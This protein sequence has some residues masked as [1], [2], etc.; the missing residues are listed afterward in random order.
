MIRILAALLPKSQKTL[1]NSIPDCHHLSRKKCPVTGINSGAKDL[2]RFI[3]K[4]YTIDPSVFRRLPE[5]LH[6]L[7]WVPVFYVHIIHFFGHF[8]IFLRILCLFVAINQ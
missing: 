6:A 8:L 1:K 2:V 5:S 3:A 7:C 4:L